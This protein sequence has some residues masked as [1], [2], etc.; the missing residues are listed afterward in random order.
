MKLSRADCERLNLDFDTLYAKALPVRVSDVVADKPK[1]KAAPGPAP[2]RW[3]FFVPNWH[4]TRLNVLLGKH[5]VEAWRLK[6]TDKAVVLF[7][8]AGKVPAAQGKRRVTLRIVIGP[9]QRGGDTDAY[10]KS[11]LDALVANHLLMDDNR[12]WVELMPVQF[13]RGAKG[14]WILLE[15]I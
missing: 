8:S 2:G 12:T 4:P 9:R 6:Q 1:P 5:H 13:E 3:E 15:D 14:T 10:W 11:T 7:Y